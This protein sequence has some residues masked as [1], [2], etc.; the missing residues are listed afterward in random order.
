[1]SF[2]AKLK[3]ADKEYNILHVSYDLTQETDPT[4]RPSSVTRGGRIRFIVES[5][6]DSFLFEWMTNNFEHKNGSV[7][8]LKRDDNGAKLKEFEFTEA[9]MVKY[10]E[11]FEATGTNPLTEEFTL[12]AK[13]IRMGTGEH[14]NEWV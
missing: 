7:I 2:K 6:A 10:K 5:T 3:V 12:S 11:N 4:G 14:V 9:Y 8:Y 13:E 1:M